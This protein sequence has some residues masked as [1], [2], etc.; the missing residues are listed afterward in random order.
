MSTGSSG[1]W[2]WRAVMTCQFAAAAV[3]ANPEPFGKELAVN[4]GALVIFAMGWKLI[5][6][7]HRTTHQPDTGRE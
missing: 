6:W 1:I 5:D 4:L 3:E 7:C 2:F